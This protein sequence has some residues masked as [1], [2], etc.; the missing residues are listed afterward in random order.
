MS[1]NTSI[2]SYRYRVDKARDFVA[3]VDANANSQF[4]MFAAR[5]LPFPGGDS[6][7]PTPNDS[8]QS[9]MVDTYKN[10]LFGKHVKNADVN[11]M[12]PRYDWT[13]N[14]VYTQYDHTDGD[15]Q[16]KQFYAGVQTNSQY[17]VFKV[18]SNANGA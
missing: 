17:D 7:I 1:T 15:L 6:T 9:T 14:T 5:P 4:Y 8:V 12:I 16:T 2:L 13:S 18:L 11:L 10:M 3:D